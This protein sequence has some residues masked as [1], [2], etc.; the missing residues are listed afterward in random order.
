MFTLSVVLIRAVVSRLLGGRAR[1]I[2][3]LAVLMGLF[4][5]SLSIKLHGETVEKSSSLTIAAD[6]P[7]TLSN[8]DQRIVNFTND[9]MPVLT[10]AGCNAGV[11]HAKAGGGQNGFELS[12]LG[13]EPREDYEHLV[14][15]GRGRRLFPAA[16][17]QSLL[18]RKAAGVVPH[19]GGIRLE[20]GSSGYNMVRDWIQ[21][22]TQ[23]DAG[24]AV[25]LD[26]IELLPSKGTL[27]RGREQQITAVAHYKD[28]RHRVVTSLA[29]FESNQSA[30][31]TV[32]EQGLVTAQDLPGNVSIMVRYQGEV[33]VYRASIPLGV[34]S[35]ELIQRQN[36]VDDHVFD[37]L[38]T[39]GIPPS[40]LCDDATFIRRV[41][42]DIAGRLPTLE[43]R[44]LFLADDSPNRREA[45]IDQL[46]KSPHYAD[47]FANK[48]TA[49]LKNRRD[50]ASDITSNFAFHAWIRDSLLAN[51]SYDR[52]VREL[53]AATGT[54]IANPAVAW[55][56]RVKEPKQQMEDVAQ[57]F[58]G[59]RMQCAQCHHHPFER[60]SQDDYYGLTAFFT[61]VGR[62]P[63]GTRGEDMI[64]HQRGIAESTN[65]KTGAAILPKAL[66]SQVGQIRAEEDPRLRLADWLGEP[67]NAYFSKALVNRYWKH[68]MGRGLIEPEDDI[69][70]TNPPSNPDL[71]DALADSFTSSGYDLKLLVKNITMSSAYQLSSEPNKHNRVDLQN[72]SRYYPK[73]MQAE[74]LLDS[75]DDLTGS[76]TDFANLPSGTRAI[77]LPDNSYNK[78]SAFLKVF[79]RPENQSVC[80][81]ERV[82]TASLAQSLHLINAQDIRAKL[83]D[84]K[85]TAASL[86][87]DERSLPEVI[88]DIY[89]L[90]FCRDATERELA[91]AVSYFAD[92][93]FDDS[94]K[95]LDES[96]AKRENF[97]D[98]IWAVINTKEFLFN[99]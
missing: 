17:E 99:H 10:K 75:I 1:W 77:S 65:L 60:W 42:L 37:N 18:L 11:C 70:D 47:Y 35:A 51:V 90:A 83:T 40:P 82:E 44:R 96:V 32:D 41:T 23:W 50:E 27:L 48:W 8:A 98:L 94:G 63:T 61:R 15:E 20:R 79:G 71:L 22:G 73:R 7:R 56:K 33:A 97:Q 2:P 45:Y 76:K 69:R 66:G 4:S 53:L 92:S 91:V 52:L 64:F 81:C 36:F 78:S 89:H 54:V 12:L 57:L 74:V 13:F 38:N 62:K 19:G 46:L 84:A 85:G 28:G 5:S 80:E 31:A 93:R 9:V 29:L 14:K 26:R 88:Q 58:L 39:L 43:E 30:L 34:T 24:D 21:Q 49:L 72:Y 6:A 16:P 55:Y 68:F 67:G 59:V 86:A 95:P 87:A 3:T 25:S